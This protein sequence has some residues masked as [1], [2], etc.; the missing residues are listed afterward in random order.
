MPVPATDEEVKSQC[1]M[2]WEK[3]GKV[4]F[5]QVGEAILKRKDNGKV[6]GIHKV[7]QGNS[8]RTWAVEWDNSSGSY[9][10]KHKIPVCA[11]L[12]ELIC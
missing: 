12:K 8:I 7:K 3:N 1:V 9:F 5:E 11:E 2:K 10:P 4:V 6:I